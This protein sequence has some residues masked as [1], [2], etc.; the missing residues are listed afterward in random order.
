MYDG[1]I[2][3][4]KQTSVLRITSTKNSS[5]SGCLWHSLKQ[6]IDLGFKTSFAFKFVNP[7]VSKGGKDGNVNQSIM[8]GSMAGTPRNRENK[9]GPGAG[10]N[11]PSLPKGKQYEAAVAFVIQN[12]REVIP[13]KK[14]MPISTTD[15]NQF[16]AIKF[17]TK[18][19]SGA[20]GN[21][22]GPMA[23]R[24]AALNQLKPQVQLAHYVQ[25]VA[26]A[27][28]NIGKIRNII[29][30]NEFNNAQNKRE[31]IL[32]QKEIATDDD[33][34]INF[35]DNYFKQVI[36]DYNK[37][38]EELK[39]SFMDAN[40]MGANQNIVVRDPIIKMQLKLTDFISMDNGSAFLG[41]THETSNLHN[42]LF[43][44]NW[45]FTSS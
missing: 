41:F 36:I 4:D 38:N 23:N 18:I 35:M 20:Q 32:A 42:R 45:S 14:K 34:D 30:D 3:F 5:K 12:E 15:L 17:V 16:I 22:G 29:D 26:S 7:L 44:K 6:R 1:D 25:V 33:S 9:A 21:L 37:E 39:V 24:I 40:M 28:T 31:V 13:W 2:R 10:E 43:L 19:V 8:S 27:E 11:D